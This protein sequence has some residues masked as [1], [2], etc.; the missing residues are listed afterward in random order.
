MGAADAHLS[1]WHPEF[2]AGRL[3]RSC[4]LGHTGA[5]TV[6]PAGRQEVSLHVRPTA[7]RCQEVSLQ[8]HRSRVGMFRV[9]GT[10]LTGR[11]R[12]RV[13]Q[14]QRGPRIPS[15]TPTHLRPS[16]AATSRSK[17]AREWLSC[18][19][20]GSGTLILGGGFQVECS[21]LHQGLRFLPRPHGPKEAPSFSGDSGSWAVLLVSVC[22]SW[23]NLLG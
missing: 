10:G 18:S 4:G 23:W 8:V 13:H 3:G 22:R 21:S 14:V 9:L 1:S 11:R 16:S 6:Q 15:S 19:T 5:G 17:H 2:S 12:Q 20:P 7:T